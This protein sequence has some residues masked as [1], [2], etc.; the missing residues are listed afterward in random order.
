[1]KKKR[2][3]IVVGLLALFVFNTHAQQGGFTGTNT[4]IATVEQAL[5]LRDDSPVILRGKIISFLGNNRYLFLD[6]TGTITIEIE[7]KAWGNVSVD[8]NDTVEISGEID[9]SF[10]GVEV[11]VKSIRKL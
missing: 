11:E 9:R 6:N 7:R 10:K 3:L 5:T 8:E 2:L 1:M 4:G